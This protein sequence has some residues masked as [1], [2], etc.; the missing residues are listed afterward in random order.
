VPPL[1]MASFA[2]REEVHHDLLKLAPVGQ[3]LAFLHVEDETDEL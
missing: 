3:D 1:V 2:F